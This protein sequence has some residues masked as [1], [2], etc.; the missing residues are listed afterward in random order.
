MAK[1]AVCVFGGIFEKWGN[2]EKV[3]IVEGKVVSLGI[4]LKK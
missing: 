1:T 4:E 2:R 3:G